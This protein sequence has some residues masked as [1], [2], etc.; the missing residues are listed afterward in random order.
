M[1]C[2]PKICTI[3]WKVFQ[4]IFQ[5]VANVSDATLLNGQHIGNHPVNCSYI[6]MH[7]IKIVR[8]QQTQQWKHHYQK[9]H[10]NQL[11]KV[12]PQAKAY[13]TQYHRSISPE[14]W[15]LQMNMTFSFCLERTS[16]S[17]EKISC[18]WHIVLQLITLSNHHE[19]ALILVYYCINW[20]CY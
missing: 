20:K 17:P 13:C 19:T 18:T 11:F 8:K 6:K 16:T 5:D 14:D 1:T 15:W 12:Q 9:V 4:R 2:L 7:D 3:K 10:G